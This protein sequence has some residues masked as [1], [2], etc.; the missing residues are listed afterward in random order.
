MTDIDDLRGLQNRQQVLMAELQHRTRNLLSVVQ[1]IANQTLRSSESL[2]SFKAQF[3]SRLRALSRVQSL[4]AKVEEQAVDLRALVIAEVT[5][6]SEGDLETNK[7]E[8]KGPDIALP[9]TAAQAVGLA[10]HAPAVT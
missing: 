7:I 3:N 9:A 2:E 6:H 10:L 8:V 4:L 5:A 1:A